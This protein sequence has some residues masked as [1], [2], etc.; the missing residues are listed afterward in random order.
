[1][2]VMI[3]RWMKYLGFSFVLLITSVFSCKQKDVDRSKGF[4]RLGHEYTCINFRNDLSFDEKFN[5]FTYRNFYNGGGVGIA[6]INND[7]LLD[8][9]F[10]SNLGKNKLYLNKGDFRFED[11]TEQANV[12]GTRAWS[13][14]VSFADVNGDGWMDI[15]VCNSG[16]IAGDNKQN[17]LFI[18]NGDLTFTE[19]A[20][21]YGLDDKGFSTHAVFFDFDRDGDLDVYLLNNSYQAIG[22]FNLMQ[23]VRDV[24]D[25]VGGDKLYRN[26]D[27]YFTDVSQE[28]GIYGSIIGF[29]LGITIGDVNN[30]QWPDIYI[31][32]D[33]FERDYLYVNNQDGTFREILTESMYSISAASMGAD[34]ADINNDGWLDIF[35]TD[36]L[37][38][39]DSRLKQVTTFE[40]W[41]RFM[42]GVS[43]G[44]HYQLNRNMLH[45]NNGNGTFSEIGRLAGISATDWSW[46][47]LIFDADNDGWKDIFVANGIYQD[48]TDLDYLNFISAGETVKKIISKNGVNYKALIDPIPITPIPNYF[49]HNQ[50]NLTFTNKSRDWGVDELLHSNG[51]AYADLDNDGLLDLVVN[52]VNNYAS[53]YRNQLN[54]TS[55]AGNYIRFELLGLD[56][57]TAAVGT[58]IEVYAKKDRFIVEQMPNRGFQSSVDPRP[59]LGIG[60]HTLIDQIR[61][62]WP[63]GATSELKNV[64]PNQTLKIIQNS[65][66]SLKSF[67][68]TVQ[69]GNRLF[70]GVDVT[71]KGLPNFIH[72]ENSFVDFDRDRLTYHMLST[73]GPPLAIADINGDG[74]DDLY[75]GGAKGQAGKIFTQLSSGTFVEG[76]S[77]PFEA[78]KQSEDVYA[79]FFDF[80][81]DD[82]LDLFVASGGN[83][84]S[85]AAP[86]LKDRIYINDG[87]GNFVKSIQQALEINPNISSVVVSEDF[88]SDGFIDVFVGT[89]ANAFNYGVPPSSILYMNDGKGKLIDV[90]ESLAPDLKH[91][92]HVTDAVWTDYDNDG[93]H[94][95]LIVGEWM[96]PV[97]L[98]NDNGRLAKSTV[99]QAFQKYSG[100]WNAIIETDINNDG[101]MDY[102]LGNHGYNSRFK[103]N[104][105]QPLVLLTNDFDSNGTVDHIF[106]R[107]VNEKIYP[108]TLKHEM[109]AQMPS[110]KKRYLKYADY[111]SQTVD[112]IFTEEQIQKSYRLEAKYMASAVFLNKGNRSFDIL[113]LPMEAQFSPVYAILADDFDRDGIIDLVFGGNFYESK[114]E[115]GR[116]DASYGLFMKGNGD[117]RFKSV[118][119]RD[120]GLLIKGAIRNMSLLRVKNKGNYILVGVNNEAIQAIK[121]R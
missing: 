108:F 20:E 55:E 6:D 10:T 118:P 43:N 19:Q 4:E 81:N 105:N 62:T 13:T 93:D 34:V 71:V 67:S 58:R 47:A 87:K 50:K 114:P 64:E 8:I 72:K 78:D 23:N 45:I 28:A 54:Q 48:I 86:E 14:G 42:Y 7:G 53:V 85:F 60:D 91:L 37:P 21:A 99:Q 83:E 1:M 106:G 49:F 98:D 39:N 117:G 31:S 61:I 40:N 69:E 29:G 76:R 107:K 25:S 15:Y 79:V 27:G 92:G 97:I 12:A 96:P 16:D 115:A 41:D 63:N 17:E 11:I 112:Q 3:N 73:E 33:F 77:I 119:A 5:I 26:D 88:N 65:A 44:Y 56:K 104:E 102:I 94:D 70:E 121:I 109:V 68:S 22:S 2:D 66:P 110:L 59:F 89:R 74:L 36:M 100:W 103:A 80:D 38:E 51:A 52:N 95:L 35:V 9:Y 24:R 120:S 46:G 82:D 18:N 84:F 101:F 30:D 32:N 111:N 116:Y 90:T 75:I 57:N 113:E